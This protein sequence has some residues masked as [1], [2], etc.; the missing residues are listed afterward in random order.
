MPTECEVRQVLLR[1]LIV[2]D[3]ESFLEVARAR[4][5]Q[6]GLRVEGV[7]S[8]SAEALRQAAALHPDVVLVDIFLG[9]ESGLELTRELVAGGNPVI[10]ISTYAE[11]DVAQLIADSPAAGFLR[12]SE[13][14]AETIRRIVNGRPG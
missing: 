7:A 11:D 5:E 14:S 10:L 4:L 3:N 1:S 9:S 6:D 13:L 2:D 12:K 8:G